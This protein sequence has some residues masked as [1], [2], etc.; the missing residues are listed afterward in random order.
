MDLTGCF[1]N[2][3]QGSACISSHN[4]LIFVR[5][6]SVLLI[7]NGAPFADYKEITPPPPPPDTSEYKL[8]VIIPVVI[9]GTLAIVVIIIVLILWRRRRKERDA[10]DNGFAIVKK[11]SMTMRDRLRAESLKSLDSRLLRLYDPNKLKQYRLDHVS[12]VKDLGEG[13][14]GKVFQGTC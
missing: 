5:V 8:G 7:S 13:F 3:I 11:G 14:F 9:I 2:F 6:N 1:C 10:V 12:Y 4:L